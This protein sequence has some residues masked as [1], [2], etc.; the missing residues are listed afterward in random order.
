MK[1][2]PFFSSGTF[3]PQGRSRQRP[4]DALRLRAMGGTAES[5]P[6]DGI[7]PAGTSS[8]MNDS[9]ALH[10]VIVRCPYSL[11]IL[12]HFLCDDNDML[13]TV[14]ALRRLPGRQLIEVDRMS[15]DL[16]VKRG[17]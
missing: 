1:H 5:P 9:R 13:A 4:L 17:A 7:P 11:L 8:G 15:L 16:F 6:P 10:V 3:N 12:G 14:Q 2:R